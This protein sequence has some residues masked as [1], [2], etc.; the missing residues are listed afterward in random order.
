MVEGERC[1]EIKDDGGSPA[2]GE[3]K[4]SRWDAPETSYG[5]SDAQAR[6]VAAVAVVNGGSVWWYAEG[7]AGRQGPELERSL[8]P[9]LLK[10]LCSTELSAGGASESLGMGSPYGKMVSFEFVRGSDGENSLGAW[11]R[12]WSRRFGPNR[13]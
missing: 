13:R 12:R 4:T 6:T 10:Q 5:Y 8:F 9:T 7:R 3:G 2:G 11:S 1:R